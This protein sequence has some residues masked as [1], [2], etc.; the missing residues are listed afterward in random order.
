MAKLFEFIFF[1]VVA[2]FVFK[3]LNQLFTKTTIKTNH[4]NTNNH[5]KSQYKQQNQ[6][7]KTSDI[8]WD[9]E[10]IDYEEIDSNEN[11]KK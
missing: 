8:N 7:S 9:A 5:T 6:K 4:R 2:Y 3:F 11:E 10:T 1:V